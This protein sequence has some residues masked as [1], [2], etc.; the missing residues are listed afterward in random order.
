MIWRCLR[1]SVN[2]RQ[3]KTR[4]QRCVNSSGGFLKNDWI[5]HDRFA[6]EY[7]FRWG[8]AVS[9]EAVAWALEAPV[10]GTQKVVLIGIASHAD[11][12][13]DNAWPSIETLAGYAYVDARSVQR[14]IGDL[15]KAGLLFKDV[16]GGGSRQTAGHMRP[17]LYR[18]SMA[19]TPA[20]HPLT[21]ASPPD[22]SVTPPLTPVSPLPLT[23]VS[24]EPSIEPSLNSPV[25]TSARKRA[26][27]RHAPQPVPVPGDVDQQVFADWLA[28]RSSKGAGPVT[29]T[30]LT[31]MRNEATRAGLS[32]SDAI[33][34]CCLA[35]WQGFKADWYASRQQTA[36][37]KKQAQASRY[38]GAAAAIF[39]GATHV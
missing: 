34:H 17:N 8:C 20:A 29:A 31:G 15:V 36:M 25:N 9:F 27:S 35:G 18:L 5:L 37:G 22:T 13:G 6:F 14:A 7:V 26:L 12:H 16:N 11:K 30:V 23:P 33:A 38:S 3:Q 39:D 10:G 19:K 32:L 24:P 1:P 21:P 2:S 28:L 4:H